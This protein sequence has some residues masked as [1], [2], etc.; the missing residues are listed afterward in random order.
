MVRKI[1]EDR[2]EHIRQGTVKNPPCVSE[3]RCEIRELGGE[4]AI[5]GGKRTVRERESL[6]VKNSS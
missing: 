5:K 6:A 2:N 1:R 3:F 4:K